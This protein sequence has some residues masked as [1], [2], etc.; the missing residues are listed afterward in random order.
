MQMYTCNHCGVGF[1]IFI[2]Q[3]QKLRCA[4]LKT[5]WVT[6][7]VRHVA[8]TEFGSEFKLCALSFPLI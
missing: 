2:L 8:Q 5:W 4:V 1:I 6:E 7:L 3:M